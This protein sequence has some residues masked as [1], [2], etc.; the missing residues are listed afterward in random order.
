MADAWVRFAATGDPNGSDG[1]TPPWPTYSVT[2]DPYLDVGDP[3]HV[4][5]GWRRAPLDFLDRYYG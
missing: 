4:A 1:R 2:T 5:A 3:P